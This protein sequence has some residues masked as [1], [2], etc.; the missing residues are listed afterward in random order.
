MGNRMQENEAQPDDINL[1][2]LKTKIQKFKYQL[3]KAKDEDE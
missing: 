1:Q 3:L 2:S